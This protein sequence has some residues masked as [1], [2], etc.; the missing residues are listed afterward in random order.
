MTPEVQFPRPEKFLAV[1]R[2]LENGRNCPKDMQTQ[3]VFFSKASGK[4]LP[5]ILTL[6]Q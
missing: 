2:L 6:L 5:F 1:R 4:M 3:L